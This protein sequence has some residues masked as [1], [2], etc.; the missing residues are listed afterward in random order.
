MADIS[1]R[2][3]RREKVGRIFIISN[4]HG[5][6]KIMFHA[7]FGWLGIFK[8]SNTWW[9][10][11]HKIRVREKTRKVADLQGWALKIWKTGTI[12]TSSVEICGVSLSH[13]R[14]VAKTAQRRTASSNSRAAV[15]TAG[16][17]VDA[18]RCCRIDLSSKVLWVCL[19]YTYIACW[20]NEPCLLS[21]F[22]NH[23]N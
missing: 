4:M 15:P 13:N 7:F 9:V 17:S 2:S 14:A 18:F 23:Q 21:T 19:G 11:K 20:V 5:K 1:R 22:V 3:S 12:W 6:Q 16:G 10:K 8:T